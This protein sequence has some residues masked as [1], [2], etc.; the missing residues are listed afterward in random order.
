MRTFLFRTAPAAALLLA[1]AACGADGPAGGSRAFSD[2]QLK[3]KFPWDLGADHVDLASYPAAQQ[4][5]WKVFA[6]ACSRCHTLARPLNAPITSKADWL[7]FIRRM[8]VKADAKL[9]TRVQAEQVVSFLAYDAAVRKVERR[10]AYLATLKNLNRMF[11]DVQTE[12]ARVQLEETAKLAKDR[13]YVS[14]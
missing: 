3:A 7:R 11:A 12:R 1:L 6:D 9:L 13:G 10:A 2:A 5:N 8:H 4:E 14:P